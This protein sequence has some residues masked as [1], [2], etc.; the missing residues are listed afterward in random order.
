MP[1]ALFDGVN[2]HGQTVVLACAL[3][4]KEDDESYCWVFSKFL[5]CM[6]NVSPGAILTDQCK[7]IENVVRLKLPGVLHRF[8]ACQF[9]IT[10][11][12]NINTLLDNGKI[13]WN[14]I[15]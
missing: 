6:D 11:N 14:V 15:I 2:H 3:I 10:F 12:Y 5:E 9:I 1:L 8:C 7:S 4:Q 13:I